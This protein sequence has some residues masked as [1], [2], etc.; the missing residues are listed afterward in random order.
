M[1][2]IGGQS[3]FIPHLYSDRHSLCRKKWP[4]YLQNGIQRTIMLFPV[5]EEG[6]GVGEKKEEK[7]KEEEWEKEKKVL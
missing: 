7:R 2:V 4:S 1:A 3:G 5:K 6:R